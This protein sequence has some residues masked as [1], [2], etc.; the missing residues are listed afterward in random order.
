MVNASDQIAHL[1]A[2]AKQGVL[3]LD[4]QYQS[5]SSALEDNDQIELLETLAQLRPEVET[6]WTSLASLYQRQN[7]PQKAESAQKQYSLINQF[8]RELESAKQALREQQ[9][10]LAESGCRQL[11]QKVP[12]EVRTLQLMAK[13]A[14]QHGR[15]D[16]ALNILNQ[17]YQARPDDL[18][19]QVFLAQTLMALKQPHQVLTL[20]K[21]GLAV[22]PH[23]LDLL[24]VAA[25]ASIKTG[26]FTA[27]L[28]YYQ[29]LLKLHPNT[30]T[31][32]IRIGAV[33]K[34]TGHVD[35]ATD[36]FK[37]AIK[38][39]A[40]AGEAYWA[41][42][43]L[44]T[45]QFT[46]TDINQM[47][48]QIANP[49]NSDTQLAYFYF[50]LG[51]AYEDR[52]SFEKSFEYYRKANA[53][54]DK[55][56][57][58]LPEPSIKPFEQF[59]DQ[60][61]F[62]QNPIGHDSEAP[63][64]VIGLPRSGSTLVEQILSSHSMVDGTMELTEIPS[65]ALHLSRLQAQNKERYPATLS[66][67]SDEQCKALAEQYLRF[68]L[69]FR[70]NGKHFIDKLPANFQHIGLIKTL[71]PR[72]KII[73]VRRHPMACGWSIF[74]Q[75]FAG[76]V[77]YAYN[78]EKIGQ[79]INFY[80]RLMQHWSRVLPGQIHSVK[81]ESLINNFD[82]TV[83]DL[84]NYCQLPV[85]QACFDYHTNT[86]PV[87]TP[88]AQQV[89]QPIYQQALSHWTQFEPYLQPLKNT[90]LDSQTIR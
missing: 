24:E 55:R 1:I 71:F 39:F 56:L 35:A 73:D 38:H 26:N 90:L 46:Q 76:G 50:T 86:R 52:Q 4:S 54:T 53:L 10:S 65:I 57:A 40:G 82:N 21:P 51:K 68:V 58:P 81:Y 42:A 69:P 49:E 37:Q 9:F 14:I 67:I 36:A 31:C 75:F 34:I 60:D 77:Q 84:L 72:A 66:L 30:F 79:Q 5:L 17:C 12:G 8:N 80:Q 78:L 15:T 64:F 74:T 11:L 32:L 7:K 61:Y 48:M 85:E 2:S 22:S 45:H 59:F 83:E 89:R 18:T 63:I 43:N 88:S 28:G 87:A 29:Q 44:K 62:K 19:I 23:N 20:V 41:L 70:Q 27:A 6:L 25:E 3:D 13:L 16:I 47:E 33:H